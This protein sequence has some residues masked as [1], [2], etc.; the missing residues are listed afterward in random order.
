MPDFKE[1]V[2]RLVSGAAHWFTIYVRVIF[3][4][5]A[6]G[7][8]YVVIKDVFFPTDNREAA[9]SAPATD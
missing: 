2:D 1:T 7:I 4:I 6:I 8:G 9:S 5:A 3:A